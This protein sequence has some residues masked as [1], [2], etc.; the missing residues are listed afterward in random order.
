[1]APASMLAV[2]TLTGCTAGS[3]PVASP[4]APAVAA[5]PVAPA[6]PD[7]PAAPVASPKPAAA[8]KPAP[9]EPPGLIPLAK[10]RPAEEFKGDEGEF[11]RQARVN[12]QREEVKSDLSDSRLL[13]LGREFCSVLSGGGLLTDKVDYWSGFRGLGDG[14]D[15]AVFLAAQEVFCGDLADGFTRL[16]LTEPPPAPTAAE[17]ADLARFVAT[18]DEP[19]FAERVQSLPDTELAGDAAAACD[20]DFDKEW[21]DT[22]AVQRFAGS[23]PKEVRMDYV[24]GLVTAYCPDKADPM[25]ESLEDFGD[26]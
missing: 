23:Q 4:S 25:I 6:G 21:W 22:R 13:K 7:P 11:V 26:R 18:L 8:P 19:D 15:S 10:H 17:R 9:S 12:L 24:V 20:L 1:M 5:A 3:D 16:G 14:P 2:L